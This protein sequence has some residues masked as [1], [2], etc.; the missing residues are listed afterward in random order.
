MNLILVLILSIAQSPRAN[1]EQAPCAAAH[2]DHVETL[3]NRRKASNKALRE[4]EQALAL[5]LQSCPSNPRRDKF[6]TQLKLVQEESAQFHLQMAQFYLSGRVDG[7][8]LMQG[9][10]SRLKRIYDEYPNFSRRDEA[11]Y[12][13]ADVSAQIGNEEEAARYF[14][15]LITEFP[16]S[17]YAKLARQRLE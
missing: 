1:A 7:R 9:A 4:A 2:S 8:G 3:F 10:L 6:Q 14:R 13:L 17:K 12:M 16:E 15:S 5:L 11:L